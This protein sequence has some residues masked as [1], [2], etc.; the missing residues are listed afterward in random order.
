MGGVGHFRREEIVC[1]FVYNILFMDVAENG[2]CIIAR[3]IHLSGVLIEDRNAD[4]V[5]QMVQESLLLP[6]DNGGALYD[7]LTWQINIVLKS[8][9]M[10]LI[11]EF[12]VYL[13]LNMNN[14]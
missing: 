10:I 12:H 13:T 4:A 7:A 8:Y 11:S 9:I 2:K 5:N 6:G 3:Q 14:H 1:G